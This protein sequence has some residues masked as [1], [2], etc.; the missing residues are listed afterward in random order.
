M[1][2]TSLALED[3]FFNENLYIKRLFKKVK[4][5]PFKIKNYL[6]KIVEILI[7]DLLK[8]NKGKKCEIHDDHLFLNVS[9]TQDKKCFEEMIKNYIYA[10][11]LV[12]SKD[13]II[14]INDN[15]VNKDNID[16]INIDKDDFK[17]LT[18][19]ININDDVNINYNNNEIFKESYFNLIKNQNL[20]TIRPIF[21]IKKTKRKNNETNNN[22]DNK[23]DN[24]K[25]K[26]NKK[27]KISNK[28]TTKNSSKNSSKNDNSKIKFPLRRENN[29]N[30]N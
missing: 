4:I 18:N 16:N 15:F 19:F 6:N 1:S 13:F 27:D 12:E 24:N 21:L 30:D 3:D 25:N 17:K 14:N 2:E 26:K 11:T 10:L 28:N 20:F 9:K 29:N 7:V 22:N 5:C 8:F 23:Y